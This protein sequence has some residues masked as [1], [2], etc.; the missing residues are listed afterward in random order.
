MKYFNP[1]RWLFG[2]YRRNPLLRL[3]AEQCTKVVLA[4]DNNDHYMFR[5]GESMVVRRLVQTLWTNRRPV[6]FDVGAN[7]GEWSLML[8]EH[9][10]RVD[11]HAFE[12]VT[13]TYRL[14]ERNLQPYMGGEAQLFL[15]NYGLFSS[16]Q[17]IEVWTNA[18]ANS[19]SVLAHPDINDNRCIVQRVTTGD[20]YLAGYSGQRIDYLKIDVEG[21]DYDVL[22]G[23]AAALAAGDIA[24]LQFE[25]GTFNIPSRKLLLDFYE[26]LCDVGYAVGKIYPTYVDLKPYNSALETLRAGNFLAVAPGVD[27]PFTDR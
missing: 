4:Y 11:L 2:R 5:N 19:A 23:F 20:A 27:N 8:L 7:D 15:N 22:R 12:I 16:E 14:L 17:E 21:A 9:I 24:M 25:Y 26:L 18:G 3:L 1:R 6:I 13:D 10:T